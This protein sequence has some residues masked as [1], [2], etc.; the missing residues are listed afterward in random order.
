LFTNL[1]IKHSIKDY[2]NTRDNKV[3]KNYGLL[4]SIVGI[5]I[6]IL[7]FAVKLSVGLLVNSLAIIADS[8]NNLADVFSSV[9][10]LLGFILAG[11]P[12]DEK[13]PFG[14][15]RIEYIAGLIVSFLIILIGYEFVKS[16][17]D[18][19]LN[20]AVVNF[21]LM[22][23]LILFISILA[24]IWMA[25][26]NKHLAKVIDSPALSASSL[27][28]ISDAIS[29]G[30]VA[31]SLLAS[32]WTSFPL[33]G[34]VG[35]VVAGIILYAGITLTRETI[36]P[37]LGESSHENLAREITEKVLRYKNIENVHDL[38][39]HS[40]G[41][42]RFMVSIHAEVPAE[43]DIMDLH[44]LIDKIEREIS[45]ELGIS[46]TIHMDPINMDTEEIAVHRKEITE[47]LSHFPIV[48]SF[49]D[50]RIVGKGHIK[51]FIFDIVVKPGI[52]NSDEEQL[53]KEI[54]ERI[55]EKHPDCGCIII[56]D[57]EYHSY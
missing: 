44:E 35:L 31:L 6:N 39:I 54:C 8:F 40:Y 42:G 53:T 55:K 13:H 23:F 49:H 19:I 14:Y 37:L 25:L 9:V 41:P 57:K 24:K 26:F 28:S 20:P 38:V 27:D 2:T 45:D 43:E 22:A 36:S 48:L 29:S 16:S 10:T 11:K 30:C 4:G 12:A 51:N 5:L 18:R 17:I 32:R 33:D 7:L 56:V 47:I 3:R 46:L 1:I 34:Y 50:F 15:G 21:S 52:T